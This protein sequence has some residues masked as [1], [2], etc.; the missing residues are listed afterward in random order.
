MRHFA[1]IRRLVYFGYGCDLG[2]CLFNKHSYPTRNKI[3]YSK[4]VFHC[5]MTAALDAPCQ[6]RKSKVPATCQSA[7]GA[8]GESGPSAGARSA[9]KLAA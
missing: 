7:T 1:E 6:M 9:G 3:G 2:N 8:S 5:R 4:T